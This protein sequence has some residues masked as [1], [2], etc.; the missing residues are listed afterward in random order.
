MREFNISFNTFVTLQWRKHYELF[1]ENS[2]SGVSKVTS[3]A[4]VEDE[5]FF[6]A[7]KN[8]GDHRA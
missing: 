6:I 3:N 2:K 5:N 7:K 1:F 4:C 8:Y